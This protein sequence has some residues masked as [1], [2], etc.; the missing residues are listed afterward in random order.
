MTTRRLLAL[1]LLGLV[2]LSATTS[3]ADERARVEDQRRSL[4]AQFRADEQACQE[5]FAV[6][7]CVSEVKARRRQALAPLREQELTLDELDRRQRASERRAAIA[8][9]ARVMAALP[10]ASAPAGREPP[11]A[12]LPKDASRADNK[13]AASRASAR[14]DA[15]Q[16]MHAAEARREQARQTQAR[17]AERLADRTNKNQPP[18]PLPLPSSAAGSR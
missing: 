10:P 16:R 2:G 5:R 7:D 12:A 1:Y 11:A 18:Q 3:W 13:P 6:N 9:K 4:Q 15:A 8:G 17:I 14:A